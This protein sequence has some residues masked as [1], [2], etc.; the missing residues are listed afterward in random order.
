M[1]IEAVDHILVFSV[2]ELRHA[3]SLSVVDKVEL[4]VEVT[5]LPDAPRIV[6]GVIDWRGQ[7]LPVLSM[8][9]RLHMTERNVM[10]SD[11]IIIAQSSY[12]RVALMV[13]EII[14]VRQAHKG[15]FTGADA[16]SDRLGCVAGA[17][18]IGDAIVLI[19]DLDQFLT[20]E[21]ERVLAKL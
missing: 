20:E 1:D 18:W 12:R 4:A 7:I 6:I 3:L 2:G 21:E 16:L 14:E 5:P 8:R 13:D 19:H 10:P 11:R 17:A 15:D 9:R